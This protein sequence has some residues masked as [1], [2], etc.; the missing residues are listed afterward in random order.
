VPDITDIPDLGS[1]LVSVA[2]RSAIVYAFLV[3]AL[4]IGGKREVGQLT[5]PD[6][7]VLLIVANAVQ[8]AMVGQNTSLLGGIVATITILVLAR[9]TQVLVRRSE[10]VEHALVGQP[11]ILVTDG[12][13]D[14]R[15]MDEEEIGIDELMAALREHGVEVLADV[16]LAVLEVDGSMSV[17][18]VEPSGA[19]GGGPGQHR[20]GHL[21]RR[22]RRVGR[23]GRREPG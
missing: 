19:A 22:S 13:V 5:T 14:R 21:P 7:V 11:R 4:R 17:L 2:I 9:A 6:L 3:L 23:R 8:N 18:P 20:A 16:H 12:V 15:A 10:R 1:G